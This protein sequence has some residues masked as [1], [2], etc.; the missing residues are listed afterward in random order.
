MERS[1]VR[2]T[3]D[4]V[5][6]LML[7]ITHCET[8]ESGP[9]FHKM[10][11]LAFWLGNSWLYKGLCDG[12]GFK[13][14]YLLLRF[15]LLVICYCWIKPFSLTELIIMYSLCIFSNTCESSILRVKSQGAWGWGRGGQRY[16]HVLEEQG[17]SYESWHHLTFPSLPDIPREAPPTFIGEALLGMINAVPLGQASKLLAC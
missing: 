5:F 14:L 4:L 11:E 10:R 2:Q 8:T 13:K 15:V 12:C 16:T 6:H 17:L 9:P 1:P 3:G 7:L